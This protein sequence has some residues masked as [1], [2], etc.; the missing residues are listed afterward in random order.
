METEIKYLKI[1]K[2]NSNLIKLEL[3]ALN[4]LENDTNII[5]ERAGKEQKIALA[6]KNTQ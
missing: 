3:N 5:I 1:L 2:D 6:Q 4:Q